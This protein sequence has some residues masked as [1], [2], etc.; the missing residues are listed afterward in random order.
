M[1]S[2]L[3][4]EDDASYRNAIELILHMEGFEVRVSDNGVSGL[5]MLR[6][7]RPDVILCDIM[8]PGMDGHSVLEILKRDTTVA[9]IPFIFVTALDN[10]FDVRRGMYEGADD[11]LSKPFTPDELISTVVGRLKRSSMFRQQ[12]ETDKLFALAERIT[13]REREILL[14]VGEGFT[15]KDISKRLGIRINTV[16]VHRANLMRKLEAPNAA[17]LAQWAVIAEKIPSYSK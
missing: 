17:K 4:I 10:R 1:K 13:T 6:V 9:D 3:V 7:K 16:E 2:I 15:S 12:E 8:M 5:A 11:Y 14:L